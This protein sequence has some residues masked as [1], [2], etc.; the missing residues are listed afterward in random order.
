[1]EEGG[2]IIKK[3]NLPTIRAP[4]DQEKQSFKN[5]MRSHMDQR[6]LYSRKNLPIPVRR[7][8]PGFE[9][10]FKPDPVPAGGRPDE[11]SNKSYVEELL[12]LPGGGLAQ[13]WKSTKHLFNATQQK[14]RGQNIMQNLKRKISNLNP[15]IQTIANI[16]R[17]PYDSKEKRQS[18]IQDFHYI[19]QDSSD[20]HT[21]YRN[22]QLNTNVL[23]FKGTNSIKD[24]AP[25]FHIATG[26]QPSHSRFQKSNQLYQNLKSKYP[27]AN[28]KTT[29]HSLGGA[30]AMYVAQNNNI[31]SY[32]FNPGYIAY[33][34]DKINTDYPNHHVYVVKGDPISNSIL[35]KKMN[36]INVMDMKPENSKQIMGE[37]RFSNFL[38]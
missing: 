10:A 2:N 24:L 35:E 19:P 6:I 17:T 5:K 27:N 13:F 30:Q 28:W 11:S 31:H 14:I 34:D 29:G 8:V 20:L 22:H 23:S 4:S 36:D 1:M 26:T 33:T 37:H 25:D 15:E 21:L 32:A 3:L 38:K 9:F 18:K 7:P 16:S 12:K